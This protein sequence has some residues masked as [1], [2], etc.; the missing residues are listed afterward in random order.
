MVLIFVLHRYYPY[1][2]SVAAIFWWG[3]LWM[4]ITGQPRA[5]QD[6][7]PAPMWTR[8]G[9]AAFLVIGVLVGVAMVFIPWEPGT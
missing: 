6:G 4:L 8:I 7:S 9:L 1:L 2:Y 5:T 3:G